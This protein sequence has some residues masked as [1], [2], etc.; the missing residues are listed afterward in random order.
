MN[1]MTAEQINKKIETITNGE[2]SYISGYSGRYSK[3]KCRCN[4]HKYE[5]EITFDTI[6]H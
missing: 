5:F 3:I 1:T 6:I 2:T 4:V